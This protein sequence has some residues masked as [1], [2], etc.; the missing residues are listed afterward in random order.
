ML[1]EENWI[2]SHGIF[3]TLELCPLFAKEETFPSA[4]SQVQSVFKKGKKS[5]HP[6][7]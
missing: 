4:P 3:A 1:L 5:G 2:Y 6:T 7:K